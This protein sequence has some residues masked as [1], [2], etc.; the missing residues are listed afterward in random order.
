MMTKSQHT[1]E[2]P[3]RQP[4]HNASP[5]FT[6]AASTNCYDTNSGNY[7]VSF[8]NGLGRNYAL[9]FKMQ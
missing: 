7:D 8:N 6:S 2:T 5:N 9:L 4:D 1:P 3:Y